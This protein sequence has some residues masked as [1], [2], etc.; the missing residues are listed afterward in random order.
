MNFEFC[1]AEQLQNHLSITYQDVI[2]LCYQ[3]AFGAEHLLSD[4]NLA[5]VYFDAEFA[6]VDPSDEPLFERISSEVCRANLGAWKRESLE[7]E[8]LF[9]MFVRSACVREDATE[10]FL[11]YL[12]AAEKVMA[13]KMPS[14]SSEGWGK[15]LKEYMNMGMPALHHS[16]QYRKAE[17]PSYRIVKISEIEGN[18][19]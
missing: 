15:F 4:T 17:K 1:I 5:R 16:E 13:E 11:S 2:K 18:L 12:D 14:F 6:S 10:V 3:A 7:P 19:I 9:S 8:K